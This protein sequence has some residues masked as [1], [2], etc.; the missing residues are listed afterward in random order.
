MVVHLP[1]SKVPVSPDLWVSPS[2][3]R[4]PRASRTAQIEREPLK[5][6][7]PKSE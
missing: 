6:E 3:A 2:E 7:E 4:H 1:F 5:C